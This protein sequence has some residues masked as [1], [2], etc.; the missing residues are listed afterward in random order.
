M[1]N[2]SCL[3]TPVVLLYPFFVNINVFIT[4]SNTVTKKDS[5]YNVCFRFCPCFFLYLCSTIPAIW[6]LELD[7]RDRFVKEE[8]KT[9]PSD[10]NS[11]GSVGLPDFYGV[12][13]YFMRLKISVFEFN[14]LI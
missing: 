10:T 7:R 9:K 12:C 11:T 4:L 13:V 1:K 6:L 14:M 2:S 3:A 8:N 5:F